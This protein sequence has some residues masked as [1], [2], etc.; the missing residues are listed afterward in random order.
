MVY[1]LFFPHFPGLFIF[2]EL[3]LVVMEH[4]RKNEKRVTIIWSLVATILK[5]FL[6]PLDLVDGYN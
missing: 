6:A 4:G 3:I 5:R 1:C 2:S